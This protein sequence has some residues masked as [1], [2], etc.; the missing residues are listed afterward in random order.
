MLVTAIPSFGTISVSSW[1]PIYRGIEFA[2]GY[3]DTNEVRQQKVFALRVDLADP[4][5]EFFS[6]PANGDAP[7]ETFGQT[8]TM[9]VQTYG[10]AAGVN[11]NF[12]SPVST[13][14]N[15]PRDLSG[16]AISQGTVVSPH[17]SGRPPALITRSN[18]VTFTTTPPGN[19][20]NIWTAVS[21]SDLIL[22]NGVPQLADCTTSFCNQNPRTALGLSQDNRYF[23]MIVIDGRR[24]GWSD[25]ATL[26]ETGTW[27]LWLGAWNGLNLDGG[28][29]SAMANLEEGMAV[30]LNRPSGGVQRVNGNHL[31]VFAQPIA[32][33]V[34]S[35]PQSQTA[36][37]G[38]D[39]TFTVNAGG[40]TPLRYQWR[41]NATNLAGATRSSLALTNVQLASNGNYSVA[42]S[43]AV[44]LA[45]SS[46]AL[47]TV[48][49]SLDLTNVA[50]LPR[51]TSAFV[52]WISHPQ[53]ISQIEYGIPPGYGNLSPLE[54]AP[55]TNHNILLVGLMPNTNYV[56]RI[57][58]RIGDN[59]VASGPYAFATDVSAIMDNPQASYS[60]NWTLG[61]SSP[62][63]YGGYY[64]YTPATAD[65]GAS[66]QAF[67]TPAITLPAKYDV[68]IW[69][70]QGANRAT[71]V[72]V[73]I[74][75][76]GG[77][78][79]RSINQTT[80]GGA[81]QL[82]ASGLDFSAGTDGFA[83]IGNN[84]GEAGTVVIADAL[85]WAYTASQDI[86][87]DGS[88]PSWW[89]S[90]YFGRSVDASLDLDGDGYST[91]A[92]YV[93]GTDPTDAISHLHASAQWFASE[94]RFVFAPWC[95]GRV[96]DLQVSTKATGGPWA[97]L[98]APLVVNNG[99]GVFTI[100]NVSHDA[101]RFYR[102]SVRLTP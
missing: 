41:F 39:V 3:A 99:Q 86:P 15:D 31:G 37:L 21:G 89:S 69:Y 93:L 82:V 7:L 62:D 23:Y 51:P 27:L 96:Y 16:L 59:E 13:I 11:A 29:S 74:F 40:T 101:P 50:V 43:N 92:E 70:P 66:A 44:G 24:P 84:T 10:T 72:P 4:T 76:N 5:I 38:Q 95:G 75:F 34:L 88:V 91:H 46:N 83:I 60:G 63:K 6:T 67:Y 9:F 14:P 2:T 42:I 36:S 12:F 19:L 61:T 79:V 47:L 48:T 52:S 80:G 58:S 85:R 22:I 18:Q 102:L 45:L 81:W 77:T 90:Y 71:N 78:T 35:Q 57:R 65:A 17:E 55:R 100:T 68:S 26:Y 87:T 8:T 28:G 1:S 20:S 97:D 54:A 49:I 64:Q 73:T 25:G 32:P 98:L 56:F 33:V 53:T 94:L 30:L